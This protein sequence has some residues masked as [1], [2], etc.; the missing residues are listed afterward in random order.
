MLNISETSHFLPKD[1][2]A[3]FPPSSAA[4]FY[5]L[6]N[7]KVK[8]VKGPKNYEGP[9]RV[10][11]FVTSLSLRSLNPTGENHP[12]TSPALG[13]A[14]GSV[15]FLLTKN[16][17]SCFVRELNPLHVARQS[18]AQPPRRPGKSS[19]GFSRF[20]GGETSVRLLLT[21][22][23]PVPASAYR[24]GAPYKPV[25]DN[26]IN[27]KNIEFGIQPPSFYVELAGTTDES[28]IV[29]NLKFLTNINKTNDIIIF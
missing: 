6:T 4:L 23:H 18:V 14:R 17:P 12:M 8:G 27:S 25:K 13:E 7:L 19:N 21:K 3:N 11:N 10:L 26:P 16:H 24:D 1:L 20:G 5:A 28:D 2:R 15:R 9:N 22:N 29:P